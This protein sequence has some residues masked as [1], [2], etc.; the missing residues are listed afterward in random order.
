MELLKEAINK[1]IN[2]KKWKKV[3]GDFSSPNMEKIVYET[4]GEFEIEKYLSD[5]NKNFKIKSPIWIEYTIFDKNTILIDFLISKQNLKFETHNDR[6]LLAKT[7]KYQNGKISQGVGMVY[8]FVSI[9]KD[10]KK[11]IK[12]DILKFFDVENVE[13]TES[14]FNKN[15]LKNILEE[16]KNS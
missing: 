15:I 8:K 1:T 9:S 16:V 7:L 14:Y 2:I 5:Y 13:F 10:F 4:K 11:Y 12:K 3:D 6:S